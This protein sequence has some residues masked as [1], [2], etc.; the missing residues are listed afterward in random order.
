[1]KNEKQTHRVGFKIAAYDRTRP[2]V[3]DPVLVYSTYLGGSF[4]DRGL[5]I[6]VDTA[7]NCYVT[8]YTY[9]TDFP[10][11]DP[12]YP[13]NA[14]DIDAF[15]TRLNPAGDALIYST[16]LGGSNSDYGWGIV[17][18]ATGNC[19]VTGFTAS[20]DF[21]T[22]DPLFASNSG[23]AD[24]FVTS[25]SPAGDALVYSTYLG[26]SDYDYGYGIAVDATGNCYVTGFTYSTDFPTQDPLFASNS[27]SYDAFVTS[28][29]P[30]GD[31]LI[32]STYL[33]G[34]SYDKGYGIAVDATGNCYVTGFT[35]STD[36]PTQD[37]LYPNNAGDIDAFVTSLSP[38]G[39][40][41]VYSTYLG[42]GGDDRGWGIAV[43]ATGN[44]YVTGYTYSTD[45]PTQDPLYPNN[46]G[47]RDVFVTSLSPAG[48]AL[49]YSTYLGGS[50]SDYGSGIAVDTAGNCYVTGF[51]YSTDFPTQ[52]PLYPNNTGDIDAFVTRLNPAGDALIYSTYLGGSNSD[53][54]WGIA[55]DA[56]G[57]C[58]VTGYTDST[59]FPTQDPLYPN[60]SGS[61]D[62][63]VTKIGEGPAEGPDLTGSW[64][65]L[66]KKWFRFRRRCLLR[67]NFV[68]ENQG[69]ATAGDSILKFYLSEDNI[70]DEGDMELKEVAVG[71]LDAGQSQNKRFFALLPKGLD[72]AGQYVI[73]VVD[74]TDAVTETDENNNQIPEQVH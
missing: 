7:G 24:A 47:S 65:S 55:V 31:A 12:L 73:A 1:V 46:A 3:I 18:D 43:D 10:T 48:D 35:D 54:G 68:V 44:C 57:N 40:A 71:E 67:G 9:S 74:A 53:Y 36:F 72:P 52:D 22:Q 6:A 21:P 5:G 29:S 69:N 59:D 25:L 63:F 19:Y 62:A 20:S 51:T 41:F 50:S 16:Y 27:G 28:L 37:P 39:D 23:S 56:T 13:N 66:N 30:A 70:L 45:F 58:Y 42:G 4:D 38:A 26:G 34:S 8:G 15:V 32:Y 2:L 64:S 14:G 60:N 17:V 49:V 11:Q 33:G 61:Y